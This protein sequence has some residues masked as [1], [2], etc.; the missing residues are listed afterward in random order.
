MS[1]PEIFST[2]MNYSFTHVAGKTSA[3]FFAIV[4]VMNS[5]DVAS[6][7]CLVIVKFVEKKEETGLTYRGEIID[8]KQSTVL[9]GKFQ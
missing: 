9:K 3:L 6:Y 1:M 7:F 5:L 2:T 8:F 4:N